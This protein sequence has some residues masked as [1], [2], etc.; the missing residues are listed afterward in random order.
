MIVDLWSM[1]AYPRLSER[2]YGAGDRST[3][4]DVNMMKRITVA[5][6]RIVGISDRHMRE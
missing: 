1:E 2:I 4:H 3:G 6:G 5:E